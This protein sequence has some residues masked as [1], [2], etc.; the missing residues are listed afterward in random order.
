MRCWP[1]VATGLGQLQLQGYRVPLVS[2]T[3]EGDVAGSLT[4]YFNAQQQLQ[5]IAF[6]GNT[7]DPRNLIV[8]LRSRYQLVVAADQRSRPGGVRSGPFRQPPDQLGCGSYGPDRQG[9]RAA[10]AV[11]GA[12]GAGAAGGA[13]CFARTAPRGTAHGPNQKAAMANSK[14]SLSVARATDYTDADFRPRCNSASR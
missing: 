12:I 10:A 6:Q 2:G 13:T 11:R 14:Q 4:Y 9:R 1:Q 5:R 8:L 7:G 3:T